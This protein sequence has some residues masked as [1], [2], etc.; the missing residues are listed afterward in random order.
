MV[1]EVKK[2]KK[3]REQ[4][5]S[6]A[7]QVGAETPATGLSISAK[8]LVSLVLAGAAI[9]ATAAPTAST[10][11]D[12]CDDSRIATVCPLRCPK[13]STRMRHPGTNSRR[14]RQLLLHK[15]S[16]RAPPRI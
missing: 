3:A 9:A 13:R 4:E 16:A 8:N 14:E 12:H 7:A 6:D 2:V 1:S 15:S 10:L 11:T 5:R